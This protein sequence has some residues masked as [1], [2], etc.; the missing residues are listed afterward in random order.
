MIRLPKAVPVEVS[1]RDISTTGVGLYSP[2][3]VEP[4]SFL[5]VT[6]AGV[7]NFSKTLKVRVIHVTRHSQTRW[8]LG[9]ALATEL[10]SE[11][12]QALI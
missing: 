8:L 10:S 7:E 2:D 4:G 3:R 12:W 6:L 11:E 1:L 5:L 9:C